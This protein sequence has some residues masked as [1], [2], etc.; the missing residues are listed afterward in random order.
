MCERACTR[1]CVCVYVHCVFKTGKGAVC[2]ASTPFCSSIDGRVFD[3]LPDRLPD[4]DY[5]TGFRKPFS[6]LLSQQLEKCLARSL[7][8]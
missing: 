6:P 7:F 2:L 4:R 5:L 1:V 8:M 3:R